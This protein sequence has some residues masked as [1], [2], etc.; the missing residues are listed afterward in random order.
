M[1][2]RTECDLLKMKLR[3]EEERLEV[4]DELGG[5]RRAAMAERGGTGPGF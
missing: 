3:L 1:T 2:L 4:A 5:E